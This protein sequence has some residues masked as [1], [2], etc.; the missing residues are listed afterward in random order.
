MH[1]TVHTC[2]TRG[3]EPTEDTIIL[4]VLENT[5]LGTALFGCTIT[6]PQAPGERGLY[7]PVFLYLV[8]THTDIIYMLVHCCDVVASLLAQVSP[9]QSQ[10]LQGLAPCLDDKKRLVRKEAVKSRA[11]WYEAM[12]VGI[13]VAKVK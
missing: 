11:S 3:T 2:I 7:Y 8:Y 9:Y 6:P 12:S 10:V 1:E 13:V 5:F 4:F